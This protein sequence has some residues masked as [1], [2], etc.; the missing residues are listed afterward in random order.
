MKNHDPKSKIT[1][2]QEELAFISASESFNSNHSKSS[3]FSDIDNII[4]QPQDSPDS[5]SSDNLKLLSQ[6][7]SEKLDFQDSHD[8]NI[9][10][11]INNNDIPENKTTLNEPNNVSSAITRFVLVSLLVFAFVVSGVIL[12]CVMEEPI[13][14]MEELTFDYTKE[15]PTAFV[16]LMSCPKSEFL[17]CGEGVRSELNGELRV[18]PLGHKV[19]ASVLLTLPES[20]YNRN[21]GIFQVRIDFL[22]GYGQRLASTRQPCMLQFRSPPIHL[23]L[24]FLKLAP[25]VTGYSSESQTLNIK[26]RGY[27]ERNEPTSCLRVI[28]EQRA[29]FTKRGGIPEMY[30]AFL[31]LESQPPFLK[32]IL[33]YWKGTVYIWI[34]ITIF[35]VE[36]LFTL[37]CC[38]PIIVPWLQPRGNSPSY[39]APRNNL[40]KIRAALKLLTFL[41]Q[42]VLVQFWSPRD[43]GKRQMLTTLDQPFGLG[44]PNDELCFYR[45]SSEHNAFPVDKDNEE[46]EEYSSPPT[47]VYRQGLPE[48]TFDITNYKSKDFPQQDLAIRCNLRGYMAL[49]VFDARK[50]CLGVLELLVSSKHMNYVHVVKQVH[51]AL[52]KQSLTCPRVFVRPASYVPNECDKIRGILKS[53]CDYHNLPLAQ[54]WAVSPST[55]FVSH[56]KNIKKSC[57]FGT[58][59]IGKVCM[60]TVALPYYVKDYGMW[61]FMEEC[62]KRHMYKSHGVVGRALSFQGVYFCRDVTELDQAEYPHVCGNKVKSCFAVSLHSVEGDDDCSR[63][64]SSSGHQRW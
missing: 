2:N 56:D 47:R 5:S 33:W 19:F 53:V 63:V 27:T 20:Y 9:S 11:N 43:V 35:V 64:F 61:K 7:I 58:K 17:E 28:L 29:E 22:S 18:I 15:S 12:K 45:W 4:V 59:C 39:N 24:T 55:S 25:L 26:F 13:R 21:L 36:L 10:T 8:H 51:D 23:M 3:S 49:P 60:S 52:K 38:T 32:R 34:S 41:E 16:P 44:V 30:E 40:K 37:V 46:I 54:T 42:H 14:I 31:K 1:K 6:H 48:W 57:S 62:R 50:S